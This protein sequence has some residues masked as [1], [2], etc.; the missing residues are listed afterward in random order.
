MSSFSNPDSQA[1]VSTRLSLRWLPDPPIE[2]TDTLVLNIGEWYVDLRVDKQSRQIDWALAGQY[3]QQNTQQMPNKEKT[4][5]IVF[6]HDIDSHHNFNISAPCAFI[7]QP[8]GDDLETGAMARPG[9]PGEPMTDYEELWRYLPPRQ[10]PGR[11]CTSYI[12]EADDGV[13]GDGL[14]EL[15]K[16][17]IALI[18]GRYLVLHQNVTQERRMVSRGKWTVRIT[19]GDVS[20][21][22][23]ECVDGRWEAR[24][25]LGPRGSE[26]PSMNGEIGNLGYDSG[27]RPG[28]K[29]TVGGCRYIVRAYEA[30]KSL[31]RSSRI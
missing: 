20:A 19:G 13:L 27:L 25:V 23:E 3:L 31:D 18:G 26:L 21:R 7:Q 24:Y 6:T 10:G 9:I 2:T 15:N 14:H 22:R 28:D 16:V 17:F 12:L 30:L 8:N 11:Y 29:V 5:Y 4:A 1:R